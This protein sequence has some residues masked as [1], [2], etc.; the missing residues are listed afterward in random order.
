MKNQDHNH[1]ILG[2]H[3]QIRKSGN[4]LDIN[5]KPHK[6]FDRDGGYVLLDSPYAPP[7]KKLL[8]AVEEY[9]QAKQEKK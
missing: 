9:L 4:V 6:F 3:V 1:T 2:H 7:K 5:E 8:D